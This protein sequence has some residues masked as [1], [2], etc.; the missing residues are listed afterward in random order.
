MKMGMKLPSHIRAFSVN[1]NRFAAYSASKGAL[2]MMLRHMAAELQRN[3]IYTTILAMH[4][5]EV[6]T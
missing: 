4:P 3:K 6:A 1:D 2:N 5:G